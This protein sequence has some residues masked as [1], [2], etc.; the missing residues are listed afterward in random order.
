MTDLAAPSP[1]PSTSR[2]TWRAILIAA[3][4]LI[5]A[6]AIIS[7]SFYFIAGSPP[8]RPPAR[9][10]F[11]VSPQE[12]APVTGPIAA[13]ILSWQ[14]QFYRALTGALAAIR[15]GG[16]GETGLL[17]IG[18]LYGVFHAAGPGHGKAVVAGYIIANERAL[19]RG[20]AISFT[21]AILQAVVAIALVGVMSVALGATAR[22]MNQAT[23]VIEIASF[24][25]MA[26]LGAWLLWTKSRRFALLAAPA[27]S[28]AIDGEDCGHMHA[29][30]PEILDG[31]TSWRGWLATVFAAGLRPC[32]GAI[33]LLVFA[34]SQKMFGAG[35]IG[36]VAM[37]L[38]TALTT[39]ALATLSVFFKQAALKFASGRG[40]TG[41]YIVASGEVFVAALILIAGAALALGLWA[42]G[43]GS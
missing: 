15:D 12:M 16:D 20:V 43:Q 29:P 11:G 38:G 8:P 2:V 13:W 21:A 41:L 31:A 34:L 33:I 27:G 22:E 14:A 17:W 1:A 10:P 23:N 6:L 32:S 18:F 19:A 24:A 3:A 26:A 36:V 4:A 5:V 42:G 37:S 25:A 39:S 40:R 30:P 7:A 9:T 35:L 28:V